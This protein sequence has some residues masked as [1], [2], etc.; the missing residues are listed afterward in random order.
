MSWKWW[1][2]VGLP[3]LWTFF[4]MYA[5]ER[6][7]NYYYLSDNSA[8]FFTV[9]GWRL[10]L[11]VMMAVGCSVASGVLLRNVW[12]SALSSVTST[13]AFLAAV[14]AFC[15]PRVCYSAGGDGLEPL[16][17]GFF[18]ASVMISGGGLGVAIRRGE[19][20]SWSHALVGFFGLAAVCY[21]P[22]VFTFAGARLLPPFD[23]WAAAALVAMASFSMAATLSLDL[24]ERKG[25][26]LALGSLATVIA[27]SAGIALAY[28][29]SVLLEASAVVLSGGVF[30]GAG[31]LLTRRRRSAALS[32]RSSLSLAFAVCLILV[33]LMM[34]LAVPDEVVGVT[35]APGST[36]SFAIGTP[37][38]AGAFMDGPPGHAEGA[39]LTVSFNGTSPSSIQTD[40]F[41]AAG[42]GVH[43]AGCCV[44][45]VDYSYRFDIYLF[46]SGDESMV[47]SAWEACDN[48]AAC[49][50]HSWKVLMFLHV[51]SMNGSNIQA[52]V[53]LTMKWAEFASGFGVQ[54]T[55][56]QGDGPQVNFT[57]FVAP[58][59]E[60][61]DF[62]TGV[63]PG[64][65]LGP[66]QSGSYFFQFGVM[67][68][69]PIEH[70][71]W[72]VTLACPSTLTSSW[73]C[74][75][76]AKTL[77]GSQSFWKVFWR[78]GEDYPGAL[79]AAGG[80]DTAVL[81]YSAAGAS[82]NF[83]ELW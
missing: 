62:N 63:L 83:T 40:N 67:S 12:K 29:P 20:S 44:D 6:L 36:Q 74:I 32:H 49:G 51:E 31:A 39:S 15:D 55:Y 41:L 2:A 65:T 77:D 18:L 82:P 78:W 37:V 19:M 3:A 57:R 33:I 35:P 7:A 61:H 11:F 1:G 68:R 80:N 50:G 46:H 56:A 76:H 52:P 10:P 27:V 9:S 28:L 25:L 26:L 58:P 60:N 38:Y 75:G 21:Y 71:G 14:Y 22:I 30:A 66:G 64:G 43:A 59:A 48:N 69:Y 23:P 47:A 45:G 34:V 79:V 8:A 73:S 13:G 70:P 24:G 17:F 53:Q 5:V 16:R 42:M 72:R 54:W 4:P 81:E